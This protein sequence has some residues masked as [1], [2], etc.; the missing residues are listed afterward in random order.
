MESSCTKQALQTDTRAF[1]DPSRRP[2]SN[3][4]HSRIPR[5]ARPLSPS[6]HP[7]ALCIPPTMLNQHILQFTSLLPPSTSGSIWI[8][9]CWSRHD[10]PGASNPTSRVDFT[11]QSNNK[12]YNQ[13]SV[14]YLGFPSSARYTYE[15]YLLI[16]PGSSSTFLSRDL[17]RV[18]TR[19]H[20]PALL[21]TSSLH[22]QPSTDV[23][24][25]YETVT[26]TFKNHTEYRRSRGSL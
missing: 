12:T 6:R 17:T 8:L 14:I 10:K 22:I 2:Q 20:K 23:F 5:G 26:S 3:A 24:H 15:W 21:P 19:K 16:D 7:E 11:V 4:C 1:H 13:G 9:P 25:S 18:T